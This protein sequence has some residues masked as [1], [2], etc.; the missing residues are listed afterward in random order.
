MSRLPAT[1][2][3]LLVGLELNLLTSVAALGF[4]DIP[5]EAFRAAYNLVADGGWVAFTLKDGF[6]TEGDVSGYHAML[7]RATTEGALELTAEERYRC[8]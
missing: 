4:G 6:Y 5:P 8:Q 3:E 7:R 1:Q 2:R